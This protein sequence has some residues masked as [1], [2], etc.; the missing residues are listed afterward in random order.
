M[1]TSYIG[2]VVRIVVR[3][4]MV[5]NNGWANDYDLNIGLT[6][7]KKDVLDVN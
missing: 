6:D 3:T 5:K 2:Q 7:Q 4:L 1:I